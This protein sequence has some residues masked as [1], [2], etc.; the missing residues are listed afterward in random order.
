MSK[1]PYIVKENTKT[2]THSF[3][4]QAAPYQTLTFD[5]VCRMACVGSE[6]SPTIM[7]S[8]VTLYMEKAQEMLLLGN[9][10]PLGEK[11][12]KLTPQLKCS[13]KDELNPDG[14]VKTA[15]TAKMVTA[16]RGQSRIAATVAVTFS[17]NFRKEV[18]WYKTDRTG[19]AVEDDDEEID[20]NTEGDDQPAGGDNNGG[21]TTNPP[22]GG[23]GENDGE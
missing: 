13:I 7:R 11:F 14:T 10:V 21:G 16:K 18:S 2:G 9:R 8:A 3:Y 4:A 6:I 12:L 20:T 22:A 17:D 5:E 19:A 23:S 1:I 15:A